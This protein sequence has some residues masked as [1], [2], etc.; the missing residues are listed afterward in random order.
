[1]DFGFIISYFI[2]LILSVGIVYCV[3]MK[4]IW[5][6][7]FAAKIKEP[8][9]QLVYV[10]LMFISSYVYVYLS[11][12]IKC[13]FNAVICSVLLLVF[14]A[15]LFWT[16]LQ[17]IFGHCCMSKLD[18]VAKCWSALL[19]QPTIALQTLFNCYSTRYGNGRSVSVSSCACSLK[20]L[21]SSSRFL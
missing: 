6:F 4:K 9:E 17:N 12:E 8:I 15:S 13:R 20:N 3:C 2:T 18:K 1:M 10:L 14:F 11:L 16:K 5:I 7:E 21:N 19:S